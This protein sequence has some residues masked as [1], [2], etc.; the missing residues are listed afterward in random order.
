MATN[1]AANKRVSFRATMLWTLALFHTLC[2][3]SISSPAQNGDLVNA[4]VD[5]AVRVTLRGQRAR[6]ALPQNSQGAVPGDTMLE[7][8][9]LVLKRSRQQQKVFEQFLQELQDPAS[10]NFHRFLTPVQ[11][12]KRFGASE[13]D[14]DAVSG[15]LRSQGLQ[16]NSVANSR[17][18]IDFSGTAALV[19][20]AFATEMRYYVVNGEQRMA[21]AD[22]PQIPAALAGVIQSV[23]GLNTVNDHPYHGAGQAH[24]PAQGAGSDLPA[25]SDCNGGT[26]S[27][28]VTPGDFYAI[29]ESGGSID[30]AGAGQTIA[31]IGRAKVYDPDIENFQT[32]TAL[33][34]QDPTVIVP[35]NGL[36]P[37]P[38]AGTGGKASGDQLE[39]T[40]DVQRAGSVAPDA[41]I[42][43][44]VSADS[45]GTS[46]L[47]IAAQYVVDTNP[48][49][50]Y[51]MNISFGACEADRTQADV[52]FW[53]TLFSQGAA[54]G[55]STFVA[56]GDAGAAGCDAYFE[57]PPA[58]QVESPNYIC[59]S[60][61]CTC[62][63]GTEF[64][65]TA[66][67]GL[68]W[69]QTNYGG[70]E[71]AMGYIPEGGWNEPLNSN[72]GT[73]A[74]SSGG[75]VSIYIATPSWQTGTGV[76]GTLGRYTPDI[77]FTSSAHDGYFGCLAASGG[78]HPGDC[79]VRN[80]TFYFEY[81]FGTSA[82]APDMAGITALLNQE[83]E[84]PQ[85]E[86]NQR[87]YYLAANPALKVFN[88]V[89]VDTSGVSGC[90]VTTPS[91]CNN[92]T[93][94]P[95]GLTGGL[96]G[97][98]V[99]PGYDEVTGLGSINVY[100]LLTNWYA[101]FPA[102]TTVLTSSL[103]PATQGVPVTLTATVTTAGINPPTGT[104]TFRTAPV[105][106][107]AI[108]T[109]VLSTVNGAQVATFTTSALDLGRN[110]IN[111]FYSGDGQNAD[112]TS[113]QLEEDIIA[114]TFIWTA[115][116]STSGSVLSGQSAVYNFTATP[117]GTTTFTGNVTFS[118]G[119]LPDTTVSC[120]FN[121]AQISAT[122][123]AT[124][125]QLTI[126]T[127]GPNPPAGNNKLRRR[128]DRRSPWLP[129]TLPLAGIVMA[130]FAGRRISK[131][132]AIAGLSVLLALLGLMVA[133]GG[134]GSSS[135]APPPPISVTVGPGVP[136]SLYPNDTADG[137]PAQ[138]AQF[139]A[140]VTNSTQGVNWTASS[141]TI[142]ANTG[143]PLTA[144]YTAPTVASGL[145]TSVTITATSQAD[146]TKSGSATE[147]LNAAT[148]PTPVGQPYNI[149]V[150]AF[151][152]S[153]Q[154]SVPV[155]LTVQ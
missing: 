146:S 27:Y 94:S 104:V 81:F 79:V 126:T 57:T 38:P 118:C 101:G 2:I 107:F 122:S 147:T 84:A 29:Y 130:G 131:Y 87:L 140:T 80:G 77:A 96:S 70:L 143:N 132:S 59:S 48:V 138:T 119:G 72:G 102:T 106:G 90:V 142:T 20:A 145:P 124:Q 24:V 109:A 134:G 16:V 82:A 93:P 73:Q 97:Y 60:S 31:I 83:Y 34:T 5:P 51:I 120:A 25:L 99:N 129:L 110:E 22:D 111:A 67:P 15:W 21:T 125:V 91:M 19:G 33:R 14:I 121:P 148:I 100:Y 52:L 50:A 115:N 141:G 154:N 9:T 63:G 128:A 152:S 45:N 23:S 28:F 47:G 43:L 133:C 117:T 135:P 65:D 1:G 86:I 6:W 78:T 114:P 149:Y 44:V 92:S 18:M 113:E 88:D 105:Y 103:N 35:P 98:L 41:T 66:D 85:G 74:A 68:Y 10:P 58:T 144:T 4:P 136:T 8:L 155:T 61:Y 112:S 42:D 56:S 55:I 7:H 151:E 40:L 69:S 11:V 116:G 46:G 137:W 39:A 17:M 13:H 75:G 12:G 62:V 76:P 3:F 139:T 108:G 89:T 37:G 30:Y 49:P 153:T 53:D 26:C 71:S 127:T 95:T 32:L 123:G 150:Y 36:D 54:E 64:A